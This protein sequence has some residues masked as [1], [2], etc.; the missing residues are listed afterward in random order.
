MIAYRGVHHVFDPVGVGSEDCTATRIL[1]GQQK[2]EIFENT[3]HSIRAA[4]TDKADMIEIAVAPTKDGKMVLFHDA[5]LECRTDGKG[6][7]RDHAL[8]ELQKLDIGY[9]YSDDGG[10]TFPWRG[11]GGGK[12]AT[13]EEALAAE[14]YKPFLF[15][16]TSDDP[17]EADQL[18]AIFKAAGRDPIKEGDGFYGSAAPTKRMAELYPGVWAWT[19]ESVKA[20]SKDYVW[21]GWLG[22]TP[23]SCKNSTLI[24]PIDE[25]WKIAGWP[26]RT[27]DRMNRVGA[28]VMIT[29]PMENDQPPRG[30]TY[31]QQLVHIPVGYNGYVMVDD[32]SKVGPALIR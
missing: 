2:L 29:G 6:N 11:K 30:L 18:A 12:I 24:V 15:N 3:V 17:G 20:C 25:Q 7:I 16:F 22:M 10:K 32:I 28:R 23:A 27:I 4:T 26:N 9:G 8:P 5:M 14:S 1:P 19:K 21:M 31:S 13:V